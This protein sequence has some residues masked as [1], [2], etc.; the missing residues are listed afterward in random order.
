[1]A[2]IK[3]D[4]ILEACDTLVLKTNVAILEEAALSGLSDTE[5]AKSK[6]I[7]HENIRYIKNQ[8]TQGGILESAQNMLADNWVEAIMEDMSLSD[9]VDQ[10][11]Q[12]APGMEDDGM[13]AGQMAGA[14]LAAAGAAGAGVRYGI[15]A[16]Q[17]ARGQMQND[18]NAV[19]AGVN[20]AALAGTNMAADASQAGRRMAF[21]ASRQ[22]SSA[23]NQAGQAV[24]NQ[25]GAATAGYNGIQGPNKPG[26]EAAY[27]VGSMAGKVRRVFK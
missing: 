26:A 3:L 25:V 14:G 23:A 22:V 21:D 18:V 1:M 13:S 20:H 10:G 11:R 9:M 12:Y 2:K 24:T 16:A 27:K 6:L 5:V 4:K 7:I 8:L 19:K 17:A 15:P